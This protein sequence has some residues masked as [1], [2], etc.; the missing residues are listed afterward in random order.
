MEAT[1]IKLA[2]KSTATLALEMVTLL[3]SMG[4]A[5][6]FPYCSFKFRKLIQEQDTIMG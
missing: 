5:H 6:H 1:S 2:G 3:S 4:L